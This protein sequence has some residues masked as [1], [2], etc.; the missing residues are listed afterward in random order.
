[1]SS[2]DRATDEGLRGYV[3]LSGGTEEILEIEVDEWLKD[4][5]EPLGGVA[6]AANV[7]TDRDNG[8]V[9]T[10]FSFHQAMVKRDE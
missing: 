5:Y 4:G 2:E 7:Q 1:M 8:L 3:L 9:Y 6:I 10:S